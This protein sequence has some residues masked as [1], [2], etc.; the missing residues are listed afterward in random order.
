[1]FQKQYDDSRSKKKGGHQITHVSN[2]FTKYLKVLKAPQG[3]VV[4]AC[5]EVIH[6]VY[7]FNVR[8]DQCVYQT[9]TKTLTL[10]LNGPLKSEI[11]LNKKVILEEI[12][13]RIGVENAPKNIL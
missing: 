4:K 10:H 11:A 8:K 13:K 6:E 9:S 7:G 3:T 12:G 2:L 5:I 1:M